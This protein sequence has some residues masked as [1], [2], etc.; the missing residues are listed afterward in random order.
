MVISRTPYRISFFGGGTDYPVW[1]REHGG[2]VL[3]GTINKYCWLSVRQ[4]PPFF[5]RRHRLVYSVIEN[6]DELS[7]VKHPSVRETLRYLG[8][9][10]R[11]GLS[12]SHDGDL[13][14]RSGMGSSSSFTVGLLNALT[15]LEGKRLSAAELASAAWHVEQDLIGENV[16]NQDQTFAAHGG[17]QYIRFHQDGRVTV[18]PAILTRECLCALE[19]RLLLFYTGISREAH[20]IAIEQI[21]TLPQKTSEMKTMLAMVEEARGLLSRGPAAL[22]D[23]GKLL[24]EAWILKRGLT[25]RITTG[26]IDEAYALARKHGALGGKLLG[27]GGGGFFLVYVEPEQRSAVAAALSHFVQV[28]F[29]FEFDG[30]IVFFSRLDDPKTPRHADEMK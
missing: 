1:W 7:E 11:T 3:G 2:A 10:E 9:H 22:A 14:A 4:L 18:E 15:A 23:F 6:F 26:A 8:N 30:S 27:A 25:S 24:H 17:L 13:P 20:S 19:S 21:R 28:D 12:I 29:R 16:G 5:E